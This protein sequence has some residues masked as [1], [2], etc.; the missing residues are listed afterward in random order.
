MIITSILL[1]IMT[2]LFII[3]FFAYVTPLSSLWTPGQDS[4]QILP[5]WFH[6]W[7]PN[8][9]LSKSFILPL[10]NNH[11]SVANFLLLQL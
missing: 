11:N 2:V 9:L 7:M 1:T 3:S 4:R 8:I 10:L 6:V 5:D